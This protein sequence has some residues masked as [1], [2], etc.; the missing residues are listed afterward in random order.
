MPFRGSRHQARGCH[1]PRGPP[2]RCDSQPVHFSHEARFVDGSLDTHATSPHTHDGHTLASRTRAKSRFE[3][4]ILS[5]IGLHH[6]CVCLLLAS[7]VARVQLPHPARVTSTAPFS[8]PCR[9]NPLVTSRASCP[10][11]WRISV[12]HH[13]RIL[14]A[15]GEV[16]SIGFSIMRSAICDACSLRSVVGSFSPGAN[17]FSRTWSL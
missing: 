14:C 17:Q 3:A 2:S 15:C 10:A 16:Y 8:R 13:W 4:P 9:L 1:L 7:L 12:T 5:C 6:L 11:Q